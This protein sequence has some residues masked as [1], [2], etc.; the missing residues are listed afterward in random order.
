[1]AIIDRTP[2]GGVPRH[3]DRS[4]GDRLRHREKIREAIR[5]NIADI[6]AEQSIIGKDKKERIIKV[7]IR[8]IK[9]YRFVYG[10]NAPEVGEG[11]QG[12]QPGHP[13]GQEQNQSGDQKAGNRPGADYYETDVNLEEILEIMFED[14]NL[15]D[16]WKKNLKELDIVKRQKKKGFRKKGPRNKLAV[17]KTATEHLRSIQGHKRAISQIKKEIEKLRGQSKA[18]EADALE[19]KLNEHEE[20]LMALREKRGLVPKDGWTPIKE[21][22]LRYSRTVEEIKKESNA[23]VLCIMDASGSM[24]MGKKYLARSFFYLLTRFV[25]TKYRNVEIIFIA[26]TTEAKEVTE[27]EFFHKG[28]S[29]GTFISSG[30]QK[31]LEVIKERYS[32]QLW[33]IYAFHSSDGDNFESDNPE[34]LKTAK[35]LCEVANLFGYIEIKPSV[36][37]YYGSSMIGFYKNSISSDNFQ[38]VVIN[39]KEEIYPSFKELISRDKNKEG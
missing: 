7:P 31:A 24:D 9:E 1:M 22:D 11:G 29:G 21:E 3:S 35:E 20:E 17:K 18:D 36:S 16:L 38:T 12:V 14:L 39:K 34:A 15:P 27:E 37:G 6:I 8:G 10:D 23:V 13:I 33:N 5:E 25:E 28:E 26:H 30:Y 2:Q 4:A 19:T 32:P